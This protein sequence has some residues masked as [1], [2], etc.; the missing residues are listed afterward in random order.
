MVDLGSINL[1]QVGLKHGTPAFRH[2][3]KD[4]FYYS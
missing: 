2:V 1:S 4:D 3:R